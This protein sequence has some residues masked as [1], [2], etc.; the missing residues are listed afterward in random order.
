MDGQEGPDVGEGE[1]PTKRGG[2]AKGKGRSRRFCLSLSFV[3]TRPG[4]GG[5]GAPPP[6]RS[7]AAKFKPCSPSV[8]PGPEA[9]R[10]W[11]RNRAPSTPFLQ[12]FLPPTPS[13]P[14]LCQLVTNNWTLGRRAGRGG[15]GCWA[16]QQD[17][18]G[19]LTVR[20]ASHPLCG[21]SRVQRAR[22]SGPPP[23]SSLSRPPGLSTEPPLGRP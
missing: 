4:C 21:R 19:R 5:L 1:S 10:T 6:G 14:R 8:S 3:R 20:L 17:A 23:C 18:G 16:E 11:S 2:L 22:R 12:L 9:V 13:P 15:P 7:L